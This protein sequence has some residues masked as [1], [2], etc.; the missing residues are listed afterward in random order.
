MPEQLRAYLAAQREAP[1]T[2]SELI[3][4]TFA[5][6]WLIASGIAW[7]GLWR[8]WKYAPTLY[9]TVCVG[10]LVQ[11]LFL[12]PTVQNAWSN[13]LSAATSIFSGLILGLVYFSH[14]GVRYARPTLKELDE[15]PAR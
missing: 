11:L 8:F 3:V 13:T 2:V 9:L 4:G 7:I 5:I 6:L 12:G 1:I 10:G 14:L 15:A